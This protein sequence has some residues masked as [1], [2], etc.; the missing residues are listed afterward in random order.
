VVINSY[1]NIQHLKK[2]LARIGRF[3]IGLS[4]F[5]FCVFF[6]TIFFMKAGF[7]GVQPWGDFSPVASFPKPVKTFSSNSYGLIIISKLLNINEKTMFFALN[8]V[9]LVVFVSSFYY[10]IY[11]KFQLIT[12]KLLVLVF[13]SSP[14][15]VVM[16]GNIGR[17]D[18]LTITGIIGF[19]LVNHKIGKIFFLT[20]GCLGSPEHIAVA[21]F[22]YYVGIKVYKFNKFENDA[23]FAV[24]FCAAYTLLSSLWIA[25][26]TGGG[27]RFTNILFET[28]FLKIAARNFLNNFSLEWYSYFGFYWITLTIAI[29]CL[30]SVNKFKVITLMLVPLLFNIVM[31]DKTR[32]FVIA[33]LP[34]A[35]LIHKPLFDFV[36]AKLKSV[37]KVEFESL[38]G[39]FVFLLLIFPSVEVTFEGRPRAPFEWPITKFLENLN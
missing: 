23:K 32:D 26:Q 28:G 5:R 1:L 10:L 21:F 4:Y 31:V 19:L 34:L 25:S 11:R 18:L 35:I 30:K 37:N 38:V 36:D 2:F 29:V 33:I 7:R 16:L 15:F 22:L 24:F 8:I 17:H 12:A 9:L 3:S 6:T 39:V 13:V 14:L 20:L 27:N